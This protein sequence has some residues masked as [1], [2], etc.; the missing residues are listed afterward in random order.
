MPDPSEDLITILMEIH[1]GTRQARPSGRLR[2][3]LVGRPHPK[4]RMGRWGRDR[5]LS[6]NLSPLPLPIPEKSIGATGFE[7][8]T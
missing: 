2:P 8:A 6:P 3:L 5:I 1:H 7:P 4:R